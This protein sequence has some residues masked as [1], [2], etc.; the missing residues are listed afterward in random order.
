MAHRV[1]RVSHAIR[2]IV[3]DAISNR[4]SDPRI[5]HFTSV[6][7]VEVSENLRIADIY[8]SV[9]GTD[10]QAATTMKGLQAALGMMQSMVARQLSMRQCPELRIHLDRGIKIAVQTIREIDRAMAESAERS[11]ARA[12]EESESSEGSVET[13]SSSPG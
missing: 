8:V 2:D 9:M 4:L 10:A 3:S 1:G 12:T 6:T 5:H 7:R 13:G 11:A